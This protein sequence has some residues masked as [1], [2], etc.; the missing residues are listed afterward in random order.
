MSRVFINNTCSIKTVCTTEPTHCTQNEHLQTMLL[1]TGVHKY[2]KMCEKLSRLH[3]E[4]PYIWGHS[5]LDV[6][7]VNRCRE[8]TL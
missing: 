4:R 5:D 1:S 3:S 2:C 6:A 8:I 7:D